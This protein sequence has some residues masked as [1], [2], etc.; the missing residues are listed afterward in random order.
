MIAYASRTGTRRTLSALRQAG[1]RLLVSARGVLR[2][3]GFR[4]ALDNGAW[5]AHQ[6]GEPF[7]VAAFERAVAWGA[8]D[9]DWLILPDVVA[10][11]VASLRYSLEWAPRLYGICPL[12]LAVQDGMKPADVRSIVG[13]DIGIAL[14]GS[15]AW[16]EATAR[17][18]GTLARGTGARF[19]V[20]RVNT[21]RRIRICQDAG[22]HSFD[23]SSVSRFVK[24]LPML[25]A[26]RRQTTIMGACRG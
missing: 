23:G 8:C 18:W 19:H 10:G 5:T 13:H 24:T 25:D 17:K 3:E 4:Y 16:K 15:T 14:G 6:R 2:S 9:A 7:D 1:W 11:G 21:A 26:A 22:A 20:L 12:M